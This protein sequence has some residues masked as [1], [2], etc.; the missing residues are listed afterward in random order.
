MVV[1]AVV[2]VFCFDF[3]IR[4]IVGLPHRRRQER[5]GGYPG[6]MNRIALARDTP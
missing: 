5:N 3:F 6:G 4:F 2:F 1:Q